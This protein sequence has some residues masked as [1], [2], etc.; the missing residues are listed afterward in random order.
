MVACVA[1]ISFITVLIIEVE[2]KR[3]FVLAECQKAFPPSSYSAAEGLG[4]LC[5]G[6]QALRASVFTGSL[7]EE[8]AP[9]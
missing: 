1:E 6:W 4:S 3:P 9:H 5:A 8:P 2:L 7:L